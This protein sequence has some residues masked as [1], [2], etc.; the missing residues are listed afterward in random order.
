[1]A[2]SWLAWLR[3]LLSRLPDTPPWDL[4]LLIFPVH[5]QY[6]LL[7]HKA[8]PIPLSHYP[9]PITALVSL[10]NY[11]CLLLHCL[12][13]C[14][15]HVHAHTVACTHAQ[16]Y[17]YI[18]TCRCV[19]MYAH[20]HTHTHTCTLGWKPLACVLLVLYPLIPGIAS[21][22]QD[23]ISE[24]I[25]QMNEWDQASDLISSSDTH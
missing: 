20:L 25:C 6:H 15:T 13:P 9:G 3:H 8:P 17:R 2:G 24:N 7:R 22:T 4:P 11:L 1:M 18:C 23:I 14:H 16:T 12:C 21:D 10:W 5:S 19:H